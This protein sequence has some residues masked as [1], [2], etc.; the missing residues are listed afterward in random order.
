[1]Q[2]SVQPHWHTHTNS[3]SVKL[4]SLLLSN[5]RW[6]QI[7]S[8]FWFFFFFTGIRLSLFTTFHSQT[9]PK[10]NETFLFSLSSCFSGCRAGESVPL[11]SALHH[12]RRLGGGG[13]SVVYTQRHQ[14]TAPP[15]SLPLQCKSCPPLHHPHLCSNCQLT[16]S[17]AAAVL[18]PPSFWLY[19]CLP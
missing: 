15:D 7:I 18:P 9:H 2:L 6:W 16:C 19:P 4:F 17:L 3:T 13:R 5:C 1:M 10:E 8:G 14:L 12:L 11:A